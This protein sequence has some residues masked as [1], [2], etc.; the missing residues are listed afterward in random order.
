MP[1]PSQLAT[2]PLNLTG[3]GWFVACCC[4][5]L[6]GTVLAEEAS[7]A[8]LARLQ[9]A[10]LTV[11]DLDRSLAFYRDLLGFAESS[12]SHY[13]TPSLRRIFPVPPGATPELVLLDA[14]PDQPRAL[15][16]LHASGLEPDTGANTAG[17]PALLFNT[18]YMDRIH[19]AMVEAGVTVLLP[20]T[21][22]N[23]FS[24]NPFGR[25]AAY[26]DPDGVRVIL[27]EHE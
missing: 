14:G 24:G 2:P 23:D 18:R 13:D 8:G 22:L 5:L 15:A 17:A 9:R 27:F 4:L 11:T 6:V 1:H 10:T 12:R 3:L 16:L 21:P 7:E 25:E 19:A 20:P 26:L